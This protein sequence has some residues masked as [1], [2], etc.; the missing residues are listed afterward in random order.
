MLF[1]YR[2]RC[3]ALALLAM[4]IGS[5]RP[6]GPEYSAPSFIDTPGAVVGLKTDGGGGAASGRAIGLNGS[7]SNDSI[8]FR[9]SHIEFWG[10]GT[11]DDIDNIYS[12]HYLDEWL[13]PSTEIVNRSVEVNL[14]DQTWTFS[15][16]TEQIILAPDPVDSFPEVANLIRI[17]I[18]AGI[19]SIVDDGTEIPSVRDANGNIMSVEDGGVFTGLNCNSIVLVD[20][21]FLSRAAY[22]SRDGFD[23]DGLGLTATEEDVLSAIYQ[24]GNEGRI[25]VN[26]ALFMPM[27]PIDLSGVGSISELLVDFRWSLDGSIT[28]NGTNYVMED[29]TGN[30]LCFDFQVTV[31]VVP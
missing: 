25:D 10:V 28:H 19:I 20:R 6:F 31:T 29:R 5:C 2:I 12:G 21:E 1:M 27:D 17:D 13:E 14:N 15:A 22:I 18:G 7:D 16:E 8:S 24:A 11:V 30:G 9:S 3:A 26:G 23:V 4:A